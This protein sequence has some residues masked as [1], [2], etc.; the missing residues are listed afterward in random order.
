MITRAVY[1]G[2]KVFRTA[3]KSLLL[4]VLDQQWKEHL[5]A[6]EQ[7]RQSIGL[8]AYGQ[9][10]PLN[11]YK[12]E[13]FILFEQMLQNLRSVIT[14]VLSHLEVK[15]E[16]DQNDDFIKKYIYCEHGYYHDSKKFHQYLHHHYHRI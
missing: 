4:Q 11:E 9:K 13:A 2:E 16:K 8:R 7:L 12:R 5:Q 14:S 1:I 15:E 6:L 3:E 10:D